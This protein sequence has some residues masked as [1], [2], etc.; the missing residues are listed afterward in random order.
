MKEYKFE[1]KV[2][3]PYPIDSEFI[4]DALRRIADEET[5]EVK[6]V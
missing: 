3:S 6:E 2:T 4:L 1:V 5:Y